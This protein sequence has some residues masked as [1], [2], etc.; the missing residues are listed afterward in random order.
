MDAAGYF[1][2]TPDE[3]GAILR[4]V[5]A[6]TGGWRREAAEHGFGAAA[7]ER[8]APAFEHEQAHA[9]RELVGALA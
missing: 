2:L 7:I 9:A 3:A 8:M 1:R 4:E 6:A 5:V